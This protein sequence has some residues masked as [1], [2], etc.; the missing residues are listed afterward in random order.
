LCKFFLSTW[1][2]FLLKGGIFSR[3]SVLTR[4]KKQCTIDSGKSEATWNARVKVNMWGFEKPA[5]NHPLP[6]ITC[7][8]DDSLQ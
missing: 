5:V 4:K 2:L 7:I 8:D 6:R 3:D 1:P